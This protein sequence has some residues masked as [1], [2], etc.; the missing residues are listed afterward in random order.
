M[1]EK[2]NAYRGFVGQPEGRRPFRKLGVH[3]SVMFQWIFEKWG[4]GD[5]DWLNVN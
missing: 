4:C 2:R 1:R 5:V 3:G